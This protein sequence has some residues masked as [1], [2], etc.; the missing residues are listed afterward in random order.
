MPDYRDNAGAPPSLDLLEVVHNARLKQEWHREEVRY[1]ER[2]PLPYAGRFN[3]DSSFREIAADICFHLYIDDGAAMRRESASW[4]EFLAGLVRRAESAGVI[5]LRSGVAAGNVYRR[6]ELA[7]FRGFALA[8]DYSPFIFINARD[9][10]AGQTFTLAHE[11]AHIWV[12]ESALCRPDICGVLQDNGLAA[13]RLGDAVAGE[14]LRPEVAYLRQA[15]W[16]INSGGGAYWRQYGAT[17]GN[18]DGG[19]KNGAAKGYQHLIPILTRNSRWFTEAIIVAFLEDRIDR[20][21]TAKLL[22]IRGATL[23]SLSSYLL[24]KTVTDA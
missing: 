5:V 9:S 24:G 13:E 8:D 2:P 4:G 17:A 22:N 15:P 21:E 18:G 16:H 1:Q 6:L 7:E 23:D 12:N 14:I 11:L 20:I 10:L 3:I 19:V